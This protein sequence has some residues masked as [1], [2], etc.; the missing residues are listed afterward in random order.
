M[1]LKYLTCFL[2]ILLAQEAFG[3]IIIRGRVIASDDGLPLPHVAVF[4]DSIKN[5]TLTNIHGEFD[6]Q[7]ELG[8]ILIFDFIGFERQKIQIKENKFY[9]VILVP[10]CII[11]HF[12]NKLLHFG[13]GL[14]LANDQFGLS[15][16]YTSRFQLPIDFKASASYYWNS[17]SSNLNTNLSILDIV[18]SCE[19]ELEANF[20][21]QAVDIDNYKFQNS[22]ASIEPRF[23][24]WAPSI[25]FGINQFQNEGSL[26]SNAGILVGLKR[27][28]FIGRKY[29]PISLSTTFW[30]NKPEVNI[31][32]EYYFFRNIR[33]KVGYQGYGDFNSI[34]GSLGILIRT[35]KK[36]Y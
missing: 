22:T 26:S 28:I 23:D 4:S 27:E 34:I 18:H 16:D 14:D 25:G 21:Y 36:T 5:G 1:R 29:I 19:F 7:M 12:D 31:S 6:I 15:M 24:L 13:S 10:D 35:W 20:R 30:Q 8:D 33:L 3:Q 11:D 32:A 17:Q 2:F 9:E